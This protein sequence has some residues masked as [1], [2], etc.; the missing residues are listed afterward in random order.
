MGHVAIKLNPRE[1]PNPDADLRYRIPDLIAD[2]T[3]GRIRDDGYDYADGDIMI[4]Y[5]SCNDPA[6][7]VAEVIETLRA[8][9]I[10]DNQILDSAVIGIST[11]ATTFTIVHPSENDGEFSV[12]PW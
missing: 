11:D 5:L 9:E 10:C 12:D 1:L 8:N 6:S 2:A 7:D 3:N 4:V